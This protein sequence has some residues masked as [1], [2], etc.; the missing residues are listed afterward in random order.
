MRQARPCF[1]LASIVITF[2]LGCSQ[3]VA[4]PETDDPGTELQA[5]IDSVV[6]DDPA[7]H[8][9][10][11]AVFSPSLGIEWEGAAGMADPGT[12]VAMTPATRCASRATPRPMSSAAFC[13]WWRRVGSVSTTPS[14]RTCRH[15]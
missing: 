13:A 10:A 8:G 5:L 1:V 6:A 11:M 3:P 2:T 9:A 12:G 15:R 7:I 14:P 4:P